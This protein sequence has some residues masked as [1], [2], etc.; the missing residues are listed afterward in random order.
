MPLREKVCAARGRLPLP[1]L[2]RLSL[3]L[4]QPPA[5]GGIASDHKSLTQLERKSLRHRNR[6]EVDNIEGKTLE[7]IT[8]RIQN[9]LSKKDVSMSDFAGSLEH[10]VMYWLSEPNKQKFL[11]GS[12]WN[13]H[14]LKEQLDVYVQRLRRHLSNPVS[15]QD[16][17]AKARA[18]KVVNMLEA[19]SSKSN[20][21]IDYPRARQLLETMDQWRE[22]HEKAMGAASSNKNGL[23]GESGSDTEWD[24][25]AHGPPPKMPVPLPP[26]AQ[27]QRPPH[28]ASQ[29]GESDSD[30]KWD[31]AAHGPPP[32]MPV[33]LPPSHQGPASKRFRSGPACGD[34]PEG[35]MN[36]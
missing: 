12:L 18:Q 33:P 25:A 31:E 24:E 17:E 28:M 15:Q 36:D 16:L 27:N 30:T 19:W 20:G 32:E 22:Q 13:S 6:G 11:Y 35:E 7:E 2:T 26:A 14:T 29:E 5:V 1:D 9:I 23:D 4:R 8:Q 34:G 3:G 10:D 21:S